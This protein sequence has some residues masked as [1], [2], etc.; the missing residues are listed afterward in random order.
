MI[1]S[2]KEYAMSQKKS[3]ETTPDMQKNKRSAMVFHRMQ[4]EV[5]S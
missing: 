5:S 3:V 4:Q 1:S 2:R